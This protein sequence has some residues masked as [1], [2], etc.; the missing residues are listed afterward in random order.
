M[1]MK[2]FLAAALFILG[3]VVGI[4]VR[5]YYNIPLAESINIVDTAT[6]VTTIFLA[7][8]IPAVIDRQMQVKH[9]K[10]D[11]VIDRLDELQSLYR[12]VNMS[13]QQGTVSRR[14][15]LSVGNSLDVGIHRLETI[16]KLIEFLELKESVDGDVRR[17][18]ALCRDYRELLG[19]LTPEGDQFTYADDVRD[20][21]EDLYNKIDRSTALLMFRIND[22]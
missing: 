5:H 14:D 17:I 21:E 10:R 16:A 19:A 15:Y 8:Y 12:R 2:Y 18:L 4:A 22:I 6:L 1:L 11:L 9:D 13:I 7:V 3:L 20:K